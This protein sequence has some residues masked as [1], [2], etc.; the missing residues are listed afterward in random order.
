MNGI[1]FTVKGVKLFKGRTESGTEASITKDE[2]LYFQI[3]M[4]HP[5]TT[6]ITY[7]PG[8]ASMTAFLLKRD[9]QQ[10][11]EYVGSGKSSKPVCTS[12]CGVPGAVLLK[13]ITTHTAIGGGTQC[14]PKWTST[15]CVCVETCPYGHADNINTFMIAPTAYK[16]AC[17][18]ENCKCPVNC[19]YNVNTEF[20][21]CN[22]ACGEKGSKIKKINITVAAAHKGF[23]CPAYGAKESCIGNYET[24]KCDC[25]GNVMDRCGICGGR[26]NCVG[27]DDLAVLPDGSAILPDETEESGYRKV[28]GYR[29]KVTDRCGVCDG[30]GSTCAAKFTLMAENKKAT[31]QTL[32]IA[33]PLIIAAVVMSIFITLFACLYCDC[34][35]QDNLTEYEAVS[36]GAPRQDVENV[37]KMF[38][39][40]F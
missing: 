39:L 35:K 37:Q 24:G 10:K 30:D 25:D 8:L 1:T 11:E 23:P 7:K 14:L 32:K 34:K 38:N 31:S 22:A 33:L 19:K 5:E 2:Y 4:D 28:P 36:L 6:Q 29:K 21:P 3:P 13:R 15:P 16:G 12:V 20:E 26:N 9:C 17:F 27:C 40:K 18:Y